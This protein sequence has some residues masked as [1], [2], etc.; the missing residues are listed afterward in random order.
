MHVIRSTS[1]AFR[2]RLQRL[3]VLACLLG[4]T[5]SAS[6]SCPAAAP[7]D[8]SQ[9]TFREVQVGTLGFDSH[10]TYGNK[11]AF[12]YL[13]SSTATGQPMPLFVVLHGTAGNPTLAIG[14][15]SIIRNLWAGAAEAGGFIVAAPVASGS[16]GSWVAPVNETDAPSDYDVLFAL[17]HR[18]EREYAIDPTRIYLWGFSSGGHVTL[19][20]A[21]KRTHRQLS[22]AMFAGFGVSAGVSAGLA[23]AGLNSAECA[24]VVFA[25]GTSKRPI[26]VHIGQ[27]DPLWTRTL[28]DRA[29]FVGNGWIE[30]VTFFWHPFAGGH[31]VP[32]A[33]AL[34][35][36]NNLC[37]FAN[38]GDEIPAALL[39]ARPFRVDSQAHPSLKPAQ[40]RALEN[41][42]P[43]LRAQDRKR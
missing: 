40:R 34:Q 30:G 17:I 38:R 16:L 37:G 3:L 11:F 18:L 41:A 4:A 6:A 25:T 26:D 20:I 32:T 33:H 36:W 5:A 10:P 13:P 27:L 42:I 23:C 1:Y 24:R 15:A 28:E 35:I 19:D 43:G 14:Q 21:L 9:G 2:Y 7:P 29:R 12:V 31:E 39:I 22:S 8:T